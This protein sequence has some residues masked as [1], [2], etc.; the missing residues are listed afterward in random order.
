[1]VNGVYELIDSAEVT[2]TED[3]EVYAYLRHGTGP[4]EGQALLVVA[5]FTDGVLTRTFTEPAGKRTL[6]SSN[7]TD[8]AGATLRPYEA[9]I[10]LYERD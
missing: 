8:D 4:T 6:I 7:Y 3:A 9:K 1:M 10:Y 2:A 5:N